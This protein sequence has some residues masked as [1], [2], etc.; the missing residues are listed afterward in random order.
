MREALTEALQDYDGALCVVAHDRHL[1][2]ATTDEL[3]LVADGA[4]TPFDGDLDDYRDYVLSRRRRSREDAR[5][6]A[7]ERT[8]TIDRKAQKRAEAQARQ[9]QSDARKPF[10]LKQSALEKE[11][12]ALAAEKAALDAWLAG[13][14]RLRRRRARGAEGGARA[15]G[16]SHLDAGAPRVRVAGAGRGTRA[17]GRSNGELTRHCGRLK[18]AP[19]ASLP[20]WFGR[21]GFLAGQ[22]SA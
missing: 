22:A 4:V 14:G 13:A 8:G 9:R 3:W 18:P 15:A 16:R 20:P 12:E 5:A 7:S 10:L 11:M 21:R 17:A 6:G 2:R 1:L 19:Q